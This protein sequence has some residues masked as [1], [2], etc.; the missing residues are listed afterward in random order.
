MSRDFSWWLGEFRQAFPVFLADW[1]CDNHQDVLDQEL[2]RLGRES[3]LRHTQGSIDQNKVAAW[4]VEMSTIMPSILSELQR[5]NSPLQQE[6]LD[7]LQPDYRLD[8]TTGRDVAWSD[9]LCV[10]LV[11]VLTK[12]LSRTQWWKENLSDLRRE[13]WK[14]R[15]VA[16][17]MES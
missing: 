2:S 9:R 1:W 15:A 5:D 16:K 8:P 6:L 10:R 17:V 3:L 11:E 13:A 7:L 14:Y 4:F 12:Y